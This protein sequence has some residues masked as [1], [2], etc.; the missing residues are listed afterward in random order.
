MTPADFRE[1]RYKL[2]LTQHGLASALKMGEHG[3]KSI[4]QWEGDDNV[5]GVPGAVQVAV[6]YM[7]AEQGL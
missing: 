5:R 3:W 4:S 6:E 7:L 1:A 2:G